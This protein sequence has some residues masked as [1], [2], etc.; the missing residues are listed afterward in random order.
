MRL[1]RVVTGA[2]TLGI[3]AVLLGCTS[4]MPSAT[5]VIRYSQTAGDKEIGYSQAVRHGN[6]LYIS[7]T[8][9]WQEQGGFPA[10][11]GQQMVLAYGH[12]EETLRHFNA[13][14]AD[15]VLERVYTTDLEALKKDLATRRRFYGDNNFP[16]ATA[17]QVTRLWESD[18]LIE[19]EL[20]VALRT[21]T[22]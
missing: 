19:I 6:L 1:K 7:G 4:Q 2:L 10:E 11:L 17:V 8:V 20:V 16:A 14:F 21:S 12:L 18:V 3:A 13:T 5:E 15:V 9:G 22:Q